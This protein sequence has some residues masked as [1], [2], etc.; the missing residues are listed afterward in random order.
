[1]KTLAS[2]FEKFK[3]LKNPKEEKEKIASIVSR[4]LGIEISSDKISITKG[5]LMFN[6]DTYIKTEIFMKKDLILNT[7]K[8]EGFKEISNIR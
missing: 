5:T 8:E 3:H 2:F 6:T 7:L 4:A 1:M